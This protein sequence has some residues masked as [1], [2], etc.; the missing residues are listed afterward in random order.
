MAEPCTFALEKLVVYLERVYLMSRQRAAILAHVVNCRCQR[1]GKAPQDTVIVL[2]PA[3]KKYHLK[4]VV[5]DI[6]SRRK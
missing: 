1:A 4:M 5:F 2:L 6:L 3:C